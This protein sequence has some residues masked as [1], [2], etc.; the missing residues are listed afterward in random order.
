MDKERGWDGICNN[1]ANVAGWLEGA[2]VRLYKMWGGQ[3]DVGNY[4]LRFWDHLVREFADPLICRFSS[5]FLSVV[6]QHNF[7]CK[8]LDSIHNEWKYEGIKLNPGITE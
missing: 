8:E 1:L 3:R 6:L 5:S 7:Y 4:R 2:Y